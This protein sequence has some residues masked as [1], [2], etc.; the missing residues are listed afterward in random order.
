ML[1]K[2][3]LVVGIVCVVLVVAMLFVYNKPHHSV[4]KADALV[5]AKT[6]VTAFDENEEDANKRFLD[7]VLEVKGRV[8]EVIKQE[9]N[10]ILLLGDDGLFS[11]V[12]CTLAHDQ[13]SV[14]YGL[15][16]GDEV[17]VRGI[18]TGFLLDVVL[19]NCKVVTE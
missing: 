2:V 8:K 5:D 15:K 11:A 14:A 19:V 17:V 3:I 7:K 4:D 13:D 10:Y 18:C 16:A 12:S 6:L 1:K 9:D